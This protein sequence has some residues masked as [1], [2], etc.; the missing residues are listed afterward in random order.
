MDFIKYI[1]WSFVLGGHL[2]PLLVIGETVR[3]IF[4]ASAAIGSLTQ[5]C[6][7]LITYI[8]KRL[9]IAIPV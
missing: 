5:Q 3:I 9:E 8:Q 1:G 6:S 4:T 7:V 2:I